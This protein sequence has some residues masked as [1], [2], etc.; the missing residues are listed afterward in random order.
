MESLPVEN[1]ELYE[2]SD[3]LH[4]NESSAGTQYVVMPNLMTDSVAFGA[5]GLYFCL[6]LIGLCG[7][8]TVLCVLHQM[9]GILKASADNT[10]LYVI[11]LCLVDLC[12]IVS[13]PMTIS[14]MIFGK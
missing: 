7:N 11:A 12:V 2:E 5:A 1:N 10:F 3:S 13:L 14:K 9:R 6:F 8:V 4:F